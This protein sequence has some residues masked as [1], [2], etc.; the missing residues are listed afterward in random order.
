MVAENVKNITTVS[1]GPN[2]KKQDVLKMKSAAQL[3]QLN[4]KYLSVDAVT[5]VRF[6]LNRTIVF[7]RSSTPGNGA[8][9]VSLYSMKLGRG[10]SFQYANSK[11]ICHI[12]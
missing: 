1:R 11:P 7:Y 4:S 10:Y 8:C 9:Q 2:S 5:G 6:E 3:V 12:R